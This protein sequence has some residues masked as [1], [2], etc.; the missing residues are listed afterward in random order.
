MGVL[1][2][3]IHHHHQHPLTVCAET[4]QPLCAVGTDL[5]SSVAILKVSALFRHL[6][7]LFGLCGRCVGIDGIVE[8]LLR[9]HLRRAFA[10]RYKLQLPNLIGDVLCGSVNRHAVQPFRLREQNHLRVDGQQL[11]DVPLA[12]GQVLLGDGNVETLPL[13]NGTGRQKLFRMLHRVAGALF[14]FELHP[15]FGGCL[16]VKR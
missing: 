10:K 2:S 15:V 6:D 13:L 3:H 1:K 5:P 9:A 14:V 12:D 11:L 4:M 7:Y 8:T 16:R